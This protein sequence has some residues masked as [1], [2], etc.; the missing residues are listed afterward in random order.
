MCTTQLLFVFAE[1][2]VVNGS[3]HVPTAESALLMGFQRSYLGTQATLIIVIVN[4]LGS[5]MKL[6]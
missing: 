5:T 3:L 4:T 6:E 2:I 1:L